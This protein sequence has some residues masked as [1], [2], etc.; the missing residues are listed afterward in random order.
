MNN[1]V[2]ATPVTVDLNIEVLDHRVELMAAAAGTC[3]TTSCCS[4]TVKEVAA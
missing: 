2:K 1:L 4:S 3:S